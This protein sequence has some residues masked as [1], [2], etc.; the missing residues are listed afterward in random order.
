MEKI[1]H[2]LS[3]ANSERMKAAV[4]ILM[5][6]KL[7]FEIRNIIRDKQG[8]VYFI[9]IKGLIHLKKDMIVLNVYASIDVSSKEIK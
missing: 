4:A 1:Y 7:D 3:Y 5:S 8:Y 6:D 9:T 2:A